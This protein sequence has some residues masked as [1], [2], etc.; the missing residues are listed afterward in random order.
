M[1]ADS[2]YSA[3]VVS[4]ETEPAAI[5]QLAALP[6]Y[7]Q[8]TFPGNPVVAYAA[9]QVVQAD[10]TRVMVT[11]G[12]DANQS[13]GYRRDRLL[14]FAQE[15]PT[16]AEAPK[17]VL[18]AGQ[19]SEQIGKGEDAR[20]CYRYL[21]EHF[22]ASPQAHK[23]SG[24]LW[25]LGSAGEPLQFTLPLL[26]SEH[27]PNGPTCDVGQLRGRILVVYFWSST[28]PQVVQEF[29]ALK[30]I[31]D[32]FLNRGMEV[33]YVNLDTDPAQGRAFLSGRLTAGEHLYQRG[34][35]DGPV[36]EKYGIHTLPEAFIVGRDGT[37]IRHSL[38][39]VE[40]EKELTGL[41]PRG[42]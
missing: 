24:A 28:A 34:G 29:A 38:K 16:S 27:K 10:C 33:V 4:P 8:R 3:A 7:I 13:L 17:A 12:G 31:T 21:A 26:F 14:R 9:L 11:A 35:L 37:V 39:A 25:R 2:V 5:K 15:Y 22:P 30:Q 6:E 19:L 41:L 42:R 40:L 20:T 36:A 1:A 18:E 23:V 32:R